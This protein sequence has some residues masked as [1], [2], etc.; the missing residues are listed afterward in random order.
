MSLPLP[1]ELCGVCQNLMA[2]LISR[3]IPWEDEAAIPHQPNIVILEESSQTCAL[4]YQVW[5]AAGR[6][7]ANRGGMVSHMPRKKIGDRDVTIQAAASNFG[8]G[9]MF[10]AM[11][12]GAMVTNTSDAIVADLSELEWMHPR[13]VAH[14]PYKVGSYIFGN[15]YQ[16]P[17]QGQEG[18]LMLIGLGVRLGTSP[19]IGDALGNKPDECF[20]AGSYLRFRTQHGKCAMSQLSWQC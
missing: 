20:L 12:N 11:A 6:S 16:S 9:G 15:W 4:C 1:N 3:D 17:F 7:L 13:S 14:D 2:D 8:M 5:V 18:R 10:R 19:H